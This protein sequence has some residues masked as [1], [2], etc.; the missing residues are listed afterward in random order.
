MR[1]F[2][3]HPATVAA[4]FALA[5][6]TMAGAPAQAAETWPTD[7]GN[8]GSTVSVVKPADQSAKVG[9]P[10]VPIRVEATDSDPSRILVYAATGLPAGLSM[11]SVIGAI[12]GT[13]TVAGISTVTVTVSDGTGPKGST[14]FIWTVVGRTVRKPADGV[15]YTIRLAGSTNE[16]DD[17]ESSATPGRPLVVRA[18]NPARSLTWTALTNSDGTYSFRKGSSRL[19]LDVEGPSRATGTA[20]IQATCNGASHQEWLLIASDS[21]FELAN[22]TTGLAIGSANT[23]GATPLTQEASGLVWEFSRAG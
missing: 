1:I 6:A 23:V 13:P 14:S 12:S 16:I 18:E 9:D 22:A 21:G 5:C 10:I 7:G 11:S 17:S 3:H 19:C 2:R 20:I 15:A 8:A 4:A